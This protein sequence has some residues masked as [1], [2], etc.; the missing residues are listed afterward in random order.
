M[1]TDPVC[2]MEVEPATAAATSNYK[3]AT[4]YFCA[5]GCKKEFDSNPE[6]YAGKD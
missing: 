3:G 2:G 5:K 1:A 6:K 4:Y